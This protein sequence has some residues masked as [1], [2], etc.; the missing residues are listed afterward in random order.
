MNSTGRLEIGWATADLTPDAP[1]LVSGQ[2]HCRISEGVRDPV[3]ATA[4]A[5]ASGDGVPAVS[6]VLVS[7]DLVGIPDSLLR[8]VRC[9]VRERLPD[10]DPEWVV[11]NATHTHTAPEVRVESDYGQYGEGISSAG[12]EIELPAMKTAEYSEFAADRIAGAI[13]SAW[14]GRRPG[15]VAYGLGYAVIGRN[16][17]SVYDNGES[18]MYGDTRRPDFSHIEGYEDHAVNLLAAW[19]DDGALT[20]LVINVPCPSQASESEYCLSADYWHDTRLELR[21]RLGAGLFILPQCSAAG[22]QSPHIQIG[23]AAEERMWRLA[24]RTQ[25]QEIAVRIADAVDSV[26]SHIARERCAAPV[27]RHT[28]ETV[29]VARRKL[30]EADVQQALDE[31]APLRQQYET[32]RNELA[33]HPERKTEPRWYVP[34]TYA[35]QRMRWCESVKARYAMEQTQPRLAIEPH[36]LRLDEIAIATNPFEYYLD[37]G[38]Q[39]K[40]RSRALQTF[41]VQLA[42]PGTYVPTARAVSGGSYGAIPAS[43]PVGPEG[44]R[45]L[46]EWTLA[47]IEKL[48]E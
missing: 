4:L 42:G 6:A 5:L 19:D 20:G 18:R 39:I 8:A 13:E 25:R 27:F 1:V 16:R 45:E 3:T 44:G 32:L 34:I 35:Y 28:V 48:W 23:K 12:I 36:A 22:D 2:F 9:R 21:R 46:V 43:T 11:L 38:I 40:V 17:R 15:A 47:A 30:S 41:V 24:G 14:L 26:L 29:E 33:A 31:A 10:L 7:C 37:F